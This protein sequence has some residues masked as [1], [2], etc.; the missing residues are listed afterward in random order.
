MLSLKLIVH[1]EYSPNV[2]RV[3]D[4]TKLV[5]ETVSLSLEAAN[6]LVLSDRLDNADNIST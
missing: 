1:N 3:E 5:K 6:S 2:K 4:L